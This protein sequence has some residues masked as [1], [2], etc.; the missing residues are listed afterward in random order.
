[1]ITEFKIFENINLEKN[2]EYY[3]NGN[4]KNI[5]YLLNGKLH[6]KDGPAYQRWYENGQKFIESYYI[7]NKLHKE[8]GPASQSWF[9]NGQKLSEEYYINGKLHRKDGYAYQEWYIN[10]EKYKEI[11]FFNDKIHREDKPALIYYD[12]YKKISKYYFLN[13]IEY[14]IEKWLK[15]LKEINSPHYKEQK[16][17]YELGQNIEKYKL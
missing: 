8:D 9:E 1:M 10:G 5:E 17:I 15:K 3:D 4:I 14:T 6:R 12:K 13:D 2:V 11:Y 16:K 7:K